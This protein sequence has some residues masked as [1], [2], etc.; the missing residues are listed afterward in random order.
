MRH[1]WSALSGFT[2]TRLQTRNKKFN[3]ANHDK[4]QKKSAANAFIFS[5]SKLLKY[6]HFNYRVKIVKDDVKFVLRILSDHNKNN[7]RYPNVGI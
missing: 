5:F 7:C 2:S 1:S 4:A 3:P 6:T